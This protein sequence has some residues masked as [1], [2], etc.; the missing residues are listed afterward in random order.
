MDNGWIKLHRRIISWEW[1]DDSKMVHL[2][3]HLLFLANHKPGK[4]HGEAVGRG[5]LITGLNSLSKNTGISVRAIRTRLKRLEDT[6]EIER[7]T[8][9]KYSVITV[10]NYDK[11]QLRKTPNDKQTTNKRQTN[12]NKQEGKECKK[13]TYSDSFLKFWSIY[14]RKKSKGQAWKTWN[15]LNGQMPTMEKLV[16]IIESM[17]KSPDWLKDGGKYIP[18]P[19]TWLNATGWE[20]EV[21]PQKPES[22][23]GAAYKTYNPKDMIQ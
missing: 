13:T 9:N 6:N 14:P 7:K 1:Y 2:F 8:T 4:W 3:I 12:D 18:H 16:E 21:E 11:Y 17:K 10:C 15:K 20:D 22:N 23:R 19:S 5:Q